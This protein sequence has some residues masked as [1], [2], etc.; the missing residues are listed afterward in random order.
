[1]SQSPP[2]PW[3]QGVHPTYSAFRLIVNVCQDE[4]GN[5]WSDHE[6]ATPEDEETA[7]GLRQGGVLQIAHA[8]LT[9]AVRREVFT[10]ILV[11]LSQ[12]PTLLSTWPKLSA[13]E[14]RQVEDE[15]SAAALHVVTQTTTKMLHKSVPGVLAMLLE[16]QTGTG[17]FPQ[18]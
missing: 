17:G 6:F 9:E 13:K 11:K 10:T 12:N 1:M 4:F 5:V 15:L 2:K 16:Q 14:Q 3:A 18:E 7:Q 8:L